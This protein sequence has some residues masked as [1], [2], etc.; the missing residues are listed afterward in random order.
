MRF[1]NEEFLK[2]IVVGVL[3]TAI[4]YFVF[5]F[6]LHFL[7]L[8][9][10][11]A[12]IFSVVIS[13]VGSFFLNTKY[14]YNVEITWRKFFYFPL[15]QLVNVIVTMLLLVLLVES[16]HVNSQFAPLLA[17]VVTIPIT[18]IITG[19]VLKSA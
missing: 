6:C 4:Y 15:T 9:Y 3:N 11:V 16:L 14:T 12:H 13:I 1:I 8:H 17:L 5:L 10:F 7:N 18:F 2:F 19:R